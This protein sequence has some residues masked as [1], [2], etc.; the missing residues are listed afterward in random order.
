MAITGIPAA[1]FTM[2]ARKHAGTRMGLLPQR[3]TKNLLPVLAL[4]ET[5]G[6]LA[7]MSYA[8]LYEAGNLVNLPDKRIGFYNFCLW[9][10]AAGELQCL[11][12]KHLQAMG[13]SLLQL[14]LA[15]V[16]VYS[17]LVFILFHLPFVLNVNC[18]GQGEGWKMIHIILF[19]KMIILSG[20]LGMFLLQ[21]SQWIH[22]SDF[23]GGFLALLG[24]QAL[25][26]LQILTVTVY[27]SWAKHT[28][29]CQNHLTEEALP[30]KI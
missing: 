2:V 8:L 1:A 10:D 7:L 28:H 11:D 19:I 12:S 16:C 13:I 9:D 25:L 24:T 4:L 22:P 3:R 17:C 6:T 21:T 15:R 23:T 29:M 30:T 27:L 18:T 26:L 5:V 20:G 14:G